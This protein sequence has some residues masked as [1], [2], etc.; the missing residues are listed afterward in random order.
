VFFI[1]SLLLATP[2]ASNAFA[3]SS[4]EIKS[5]DPGA[6]AMAYDLFLLRPVSAVATVGGSIVWV[7][8]LPFS[9]LGGNAGKAGKKLIA[10]PLK[11]TLYRPLGNF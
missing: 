1:A 5:N 2:L 10:D 6:G 3:A 8:G 4:V 9:V 11:Y 7:L